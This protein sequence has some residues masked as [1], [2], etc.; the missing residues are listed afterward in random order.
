MTTVKS[1]AQ[2]IFN[3]THNPFGLVYAGAITENRPG[4]INIHPVVYELGG[5][6]IAANIYEGPSGTQ[7]RQQ[8]EE[9][10]SPLEPGTLF[11]DG[12][13]YYDR[14]SGGQI[15]ISTAGTGYYQEKG[16]PA[17][18]LS[19]GDIVEIAPDASTV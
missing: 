18:R 6:M 16:K 2:E 7:S 15:L 17:R 10:M 11:H 3:H 14:H 5:N 8:I 1:Y 13:E 19:T 4:Q 9:A 12:L